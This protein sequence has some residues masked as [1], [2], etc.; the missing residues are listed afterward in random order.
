MGGIEK[1]Y[2]RSYNLPKRSN[3]KTLTVD[4]AE[5][6]HLHYR[7]LRI[8]FSLNEFIE[9]MDHMKI[10]YSELKKWRESNPDWTE[11]DPN[12]FEDKFGIEF[13]KQKNKIKENSDYWDDR[14]SIE[15]KMS[16]DYH[17]KWRNYR[18]EMDE[19]SFIRW[20]IAFSEVIPEFKKDIM[21][22]RKAKKI[23]NRLWKSLL[24]RIK[25][26]IDFS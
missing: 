1:L 26:I 20:E 13:G 25:K 18:F 24:R 22:H 12:S 8:E 4:V 3:A 21:L 16:G 7:D 19:A 2:H 15:K 11:S 10:M 17:I 5:N 6:I 9:F 23:I 14:F